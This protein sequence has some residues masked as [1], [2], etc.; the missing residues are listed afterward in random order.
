M[1]SDQK[2]F[3]AQV[4]RLRR[5]H[6]G[7]APAG[8]VSNQDVL[9]AIN[10]LRDEIR[11]VANILRPEEEPPPS[12]PA[13]VDPI[14]QERAEVGLLRTELR[15]LANSIQQ[16]KVEIAALRPKDKDEDDRLMA[17]TS[18][19]DAIVTATEK[20]TQGILDAA[21]RID[22]LA[23]SVRSHEKDS[24]AQGLVDEIRE[25]IITIFEA[26]NFQDITGQRVT[27]VV[28][29]LKHIEQRIGALVAAFGAE[30]EQ[31]TAPAAQSGPGKP[32]GDADLLNGPQ[33]PTV[34]SKQDE[35][36]ALLASFD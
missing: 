15:A 11:A 6:G 23:A 8:E 1:T 13:E 2:P 33:L 4:Q 24:F 17:V 36:D 12:A 31:E 32:L 7:A 9:R 18:E 19:L 21:E 26:C 20:A 16:T 29:A 14:E 35:I 5:G 3:T 25:Q 34:A 28:N 10:G 22:H 30:W 27:K